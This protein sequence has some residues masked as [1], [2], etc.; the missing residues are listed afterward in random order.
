[1]RAARLLLVL[2]VLTAC[3]E[4]RP[5]PLEPDVPPLALAGTWTAVRFDV[6]PDGVPTQDMLEVGAGLVIVVDG[7]GRTTGRLTGPFGSP[8]TDMSGE[9]IAEGNRVRFVQ[10]A[11]TFV[12]LLEW[13]RHGDTL[14]VTDQRLATTR[15]TLRLVRGS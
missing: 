15:F 13:T 9:A 5:Y 1:M 4:S 11:D 12:R 2:G 6:T 10:P 3:Y 8:E 14:A 7:S